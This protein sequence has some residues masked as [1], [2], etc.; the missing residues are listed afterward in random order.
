MRYCSTRDNR[1]SFTLSEVL[2]QGMPA[3]GGLYIPEEWVPCDVS[4]WPDSMSYAECAK[5]VL[6][7]YFAGDP[8]YHDLE[9]ICH[10]AFNFDIPLTALNDN[11]YLMELYHGPTLSFKDVGAR[12]LS[13][14]LQAMPCDEVRTIVVATSGDTGSAVASAFYQVEGIR[15]VVLYPKGQISKR[16]Q[17]QITCWG[18][19][20]LAI[21]VDGDFDTCQR[22]VKAALIDP[23]WLDRTQIN[24]SN[25]INIGRF[26]P[27][28]TYYAYHSWRWFVEKGQVAQWIV[29][30]GNLGN[31]TAA[32]V[33]QSIGIPMGAIVMSSNA[34]RVMADYLDTGQYKPRQ[35]MA[36]L[37]NAM[38][39]GAP[40]N[41][42][43]LQALFSDFSSLNQAVDVVVATDEMISQT[44]QA[45]YREH[46]ALLCP[47]TATAVYARSFLDAQPWLVAA[48]AAPCK[49]EQVVEPLLGIDVPAEGALCAQL[50]RP[51]YGREIEASAL[52]LQ[53]CYETYFA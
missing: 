41:I 33:A 31:V 48:T 25:S 20:V 27:Q 49:F 21:A 6:S 23:W 45:V 53:S 19:N 42:E 15:V 40:S 8:L 14:C 13:R 43:R 17:Q 29:P 44:I 7:P 37:A 47:H 50:A 22:L 10:E 35:S 18:E 24:T 39:V 9:A 32:Y 4:A 34:N 12:F 16:Q 36:T 2:M 52:A 51:S 26:L 30:A 46:H 5:E 38:D 3:A 11:T 1:L 28:I